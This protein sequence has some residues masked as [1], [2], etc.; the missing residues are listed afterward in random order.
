MIYQVAKRI[1]KSN[2]N[3][4]KQFATD[5]RILSE[6]LASADISSSGSGS[7]ASAS[8]HLLKDEGGKK[9]ISFA[10]SDIDIKID[11]SLH[12]MPPSVEIEERLLV[13]I[14]FK[15]EL[16][17][18]GEIVHTHEKVIENQVNFRIRGRKGRRQLISAWH[19]DRHAHP[20]ASNS[21]S[22]PTYHFQ[23]GGWGLKEIA[24][25]IDGV[26]V[27]DTPRYF[28]PPMDPI[29]AVDV[30]LSHFNGPKWHTIR[31]SET[32]YIDIVRRAQARL[33]KPYFDKISN[34]LSP[35][36]KNE[37]ARLLDLLPNIM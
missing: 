37:P 17:E 31:N 10:A 4:I 33:W 3:I 30:L 23:F 13:D 9:L 21:P 32:R 20:P 27:L 35:V 1:N 16:M 5:L 28:A 2:K 22:H 6:I 12:I 15:Q 18:Q 19:F 24:N 26:I 34:D 36:S 7:I 29:I 25:K 14:V 11:P 8:Y